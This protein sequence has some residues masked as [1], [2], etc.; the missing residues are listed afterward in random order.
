[1]SVET[2]TRTARKVPY[3]EI[4][5]RLPHM[6]W[7]MDVK[8][9]QTE[10]NMARTTAHMR[11]TDLVNRGDLKRVG[12]KQFGLPDQD[13][14]GERVRPKIRSWEELVEDLPNMDWPLTRIEMLAD[15]TA[16][17][18]DKMQWIE[19]AIS[20]G[21][22]LRVGLAE[23]VYVNADIRSPDDVRPPDPNRV[24][25]GDHDYQ[26]LLRR[27]PEEFTAAMFGALIGEGPVHNA[28]TLD[29]LRA[30]GWINRVERGVY[31]RPA[32]TLDSPFG[33]GQFAYHFGLSTLEAAEKLSELQ[34][35]RKVKVKV[36]ER[37]ARLLTVPM[38]PDVTFQATA[39]VLAELERELH[40]ANG[41]VEPFEYE[42]LHSVIRDVPTLPWPMTVKGFAE[43]YGLSV[44]TARGNIDR[45]RLLGLVEL[46]G[47]QSGRHKQY[48][49]TKVTEPVRDV[50][51]VRRLVR[52]NSRAPEAAALLGAARKPAVAP[53]GAPVARKKKVG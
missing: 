10:F 28:K 39:A 20:E 50:R 1:M 47:E 11:L 51:E 22:I 12:N 15:I 53:A 29:R 49:W 36:K 7:P 21:L 26:K 9:F 43:H 13:Y 42:K 52:H 41:E 32:T 48:T 25:S 30:N 35:R 38:K 5:A 40:E 2:V 16:A 31:Q 18:D 8:A 46:T 14:G 27:L 23:F 6:A 24:E 17:Y 4:K 33:I 3:E 19:R 37:K 44:T 45:L 34:E